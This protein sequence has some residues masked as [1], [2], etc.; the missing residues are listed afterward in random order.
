LYRVT[1][2]N[3]G[4]PGQWNQAV[5]DI[6]PAS[7]LVT[8]KFNNDFLSTVKGFGAGPD[9][10]LQ[11][12]LDG[13][14]L[15]GG[16]SLRLD[17]NTAPQLQSNATLKTGGPHVI[18]AHLIGD[19]RLRIDNDRYRVVD[20][21]SELKVLIV[22]GDRGV[23]LM[24]GSAAFLDLALAPPKE[25]GANGQP[26]K[27]DSEVSPEVI[28]DLE[29]G[30]KVLSDYRAIILTN[31]A[32]LP[33]P[34]AQAIEKFVRAGGTLLLFMGEQ[35]NADAY[36]KILLPRGLL[37]GP[38]TKRIS[39]GADQKGYAFDFNPKNVHPL[40]SI[41][42]GEEKSGLDHVEIDTYWQV[43]LPADT[44]AERVLSYI[45]GPL[46]PSPGTRG[47]GRGEG[48][49]DPAIT[50][51]QLG[52]GH[53]VFV[54]TSAG[55][56]NWTTLPA[57]LVHLPLIH[58]LVAQSLTPEDGWMNLTVG[59]SLQI[60]PWT[61]LTSTPS[62]IDT[63]KKEI[64]LE[65]TQLKDGQNVYRSR[66]ILRSGLYTLSTG[67]KTYPIA[68]NVPPEEADVRTLDVAAIRSAMGDIDMTIESD[69]P[70]VEIV[71]DESGKD[72]GWSLMTVV[73]VLVAAECFMAMTFGHYRK[74]AVKRQ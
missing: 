46:S 44:K 33:A 23:G 28:S 1:Y 19:D 71:K 21:V 27:T 14:T 60:P 4:K 43:E 62:L 50:T 39:I 51:H 47:E 12:K 30:N 37:P 10:I 49:G 63:T 34:Q 69:Q 42:R 6:H 3:L 5:L 56:D 26:T 9:S 67:D 52:D 48:L 70:P 8:S 36:N 25:L 61:K 11:W 18:S 32:Q 35:V 17:L 41:F 22:E 45:G 68:V 66:P 74:V 13:Q 31:V 53:V 64:P 20:V 73:L 59:R 65:Q 58:E 38:L 24:S 7:R 54:S 55:A 16:G 15:P 40:L 2:F 29:L 72:Y 57:K